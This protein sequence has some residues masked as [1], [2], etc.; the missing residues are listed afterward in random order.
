MQVSSCVN[1]V[2]Y[3]T[4]KKRAVTLSRTM[5]PIP[6]I[7]SSVFAVSG[8]SAMSN[9]AYYQDDQ[10]REPTWT[11][12]KRSSHYYSGPDLDRYNCT[13]GEYSPGAQSSTTGNQGNYFNHSSDETMG[14]MTVEDG[15]KEA[16]SNP[17]PTSQKSE[18]RQSRW[19]YYHHEMGDMTIDDDESDT[20]MQRGME[21]QNES[22]N[23]TETQP[24]P[25]PMNSAPADE[26]SPSES[27]ED[28]SL[29]NPTGDES[30]TDEQGPA[31][32]GNPNS[33]E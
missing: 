28:N 27:M 4:D 29:S 20:N 9:S 19:R 11:T 2:N 14:D 5:K 33:D 21:P 23:P 24:A 8:L 6:F 25:A 1:F 16:M 22:T 18:K 32:R 7:L 12:S 15:K 31:A 26:T 13:S 30:D 17:E 10:S 3:I